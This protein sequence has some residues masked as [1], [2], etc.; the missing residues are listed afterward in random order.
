MPAI[1]KLEIKTASKCLKLSVENSP[2]DLKRSEVLAC[3][4]IAV[5]QEMNDE[6]KNNILL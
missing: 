2:H 1:F 3:F 4:G 6:R 5:L